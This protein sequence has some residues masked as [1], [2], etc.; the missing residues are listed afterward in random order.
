MLSIVRTSPQAE[1]YNG[2][3]GR[4][5]KELSV[6]STVVA[7]SSLPEYLSKPSDL[8]SVAGAIKLAKALF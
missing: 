7:F 1:I 5:C 2:V 3:H 6:K 8:Q 4:P